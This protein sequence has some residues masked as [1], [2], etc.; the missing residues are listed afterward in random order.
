MDVPWVRWSLYCSAPA[1]PARR[2][3]SRDRKHP[4]ARPSCS[5]AG[6]VR[7]QELLPGA[8]VVHDD[9]R[10]TE[11]AAGETYAAIGDQV[12][13]LGLGTVVTAYDAKQGTRAGPR[14]FQTCVMAG[15][16]SARAWPGVVTVGVTAAP[17]ADRLARHSG[18][19]CSMLPPDG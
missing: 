5:R 6:T 4:A 18:K 19:W 13:V 11:P 16:V 12:A 2:P 17:G 7:W 14:G 3:P 8:Y 10:G 1:R 9:S 15:I